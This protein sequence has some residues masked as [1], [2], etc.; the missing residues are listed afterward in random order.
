MAHSH[1]HAPGQ[2]HSHSHANGPQQQQQPQVLPPPDPVL[3]AAIDQ[4]FRPVS[5]ALGG[6]GTIAVCE[7]H[8]LEKCDNCNVD[9]VNTNR[10]SRL[11]VA[12]PNLLCPPPS[13]IVSQKLTQ[14]VTS[15]KEEGNALFKTGQAQQAVLR[16]TTAST[17]A[18]QR[19]PWEANQF[20]REELSTTVSNRS[21]AYF[22]AGD[23]VSAL[24]DAETVIAIRRNW[25]KGHYR[26]AKAL[27]G[28]GRPKEA[29]D[30]LKLGL[31]YEPT[32]AELSNFLTEVQKEIAAAA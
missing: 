13:N 5:L 17:L 23:H 24:V 22:E 32:N 29:A 11:L 18:I 19:P 16:Y 15:A 9:F 26:R 8:K 1:T 6:D 20:M 2:A 30:A 10:L 12:N 31:S 7:P 14:M 4:D 3:Q 25:S 28:M 27:R 21:A